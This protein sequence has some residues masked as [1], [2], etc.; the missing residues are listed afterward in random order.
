MPYIYK[1]YNY[2]AGLLTE[3]LLVKGLST[4]QSLYKGKINFQL[5]SAINLVGTHANARVFRG[6]YRKNRYTFIYRMSLINAIKNAQL[7]H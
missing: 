7:N 4:V 5:T 2:D 1:L 6:K 3:Y